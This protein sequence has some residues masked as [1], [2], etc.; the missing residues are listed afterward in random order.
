[1]SEHEGFGASLLASMYVGVPVLAYASTAIPGTV[2]NAAVLLLKKD[3][4]VAAEALAL[5]VEPGSPLR[6]AMIARGHERVHQFM[7]EQIRDQLVVALARALGLA[8][9]AA[10]DQRGRSSDL[11]RKNAAR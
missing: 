4:A 6:R 11:K 7:P 8:E 3:L 1:M 5:L 10:G 2:G 9:G